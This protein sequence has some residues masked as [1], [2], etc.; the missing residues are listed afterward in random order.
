M[1]KTH[2]IIISLGII[3]VILLFIMG[4][5]GL[6]QSPWAK[7]LRTFST[8]IQTEFNLSSIRIA[9]VKLPAGFFYRITFVPEEPLTEEKLEN[10]MQK[11][12]KYVW[13]NLPEKEKP[14]KVSIVYLSETTGFSC[15]HNTT[16]IQREIPESSNK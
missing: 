14:A 15:S 1:Y 10:L 5:F 3:A 7:Q 11:L 9:R 12:G 4:L 6:E 13:K 8:Q 16:R 2:K